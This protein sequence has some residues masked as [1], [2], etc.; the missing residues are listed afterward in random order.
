MAQG[1]K[2]PWRLE[3]KGALSQIKVNAE[4]KK[5]KK[6]NKKGLK[7]KS[8]ESPQKADC[9]THQAFKGTRNQSERW[10]P[11][12]QK[13][14]ECSRTS[15]E[16]SLTLLLETWPWLERCR[17]GGCFDDDTSGSALAKPF[18]IVFST[19]KSQ[20]RL[21]KPVVLQMLSSPPTPRLRVVIHTVFYPKTHE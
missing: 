5:S 8:K 4:G 20:G 10:G 19:W 7:Q 1:A 13:L 3:G 14:L 11:R 15:E 2:N 16:T 12:D 21:F 18:P 9:E 17:G 6:Q